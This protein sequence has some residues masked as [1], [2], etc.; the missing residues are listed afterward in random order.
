MC[1]SGGFALAMALD[2]LVLAPV[3]SQPSMPFPV[4]P[5]HRSDLGMAPADLRQVAERLEQGQL[6]A[7]ALRF[8]ADKKCPAQRFETLER[9]LGGVTVVR[10][11]SAPGNP[12]GLRES[13]H[14]VLTLSPRHYEGP[15]PP[16]ILRQVADQVVALL[17]A[18]LGP[19]ADGPSTTAPR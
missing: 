2:P 14:S 10:I 16:E 1:F 19:D 9:E 11:N 5:A 18:Q 13:A 17:R 8:C 15:E 3:A 6:R 7:L 12:H 4:T